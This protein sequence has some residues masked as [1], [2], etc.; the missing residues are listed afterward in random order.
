[1]LESLIGSLNRERVLVFIHA[2]QEGYAREIAR[3]Y[4]TD[5]YNIQKQLDRL[6]LGGILISRPVGRTRLYA[7][8]PRYPLLSELNILLKKTLSIYPENIRKG[9]AE[10]RRRPRR[11]GKP[12]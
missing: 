3:F 7:F 5:L 12:L 10:N 11:R 2:R 6:E 9:L 4:K 8:N 1:M